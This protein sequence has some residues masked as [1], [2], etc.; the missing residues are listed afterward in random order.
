M[1]FL[2]RE[3]VD[4][5]AS[6]AGT[7][8]AEDA[9]GKRWTN[10]A[11]PLSHEFMRVAS[12]KESLVVLAADVPSIDETLKLIE[13]VGDSVCALKTHVDMVEGFNFEE[14]SMVVESA[15]AKGMLIFEDRKFADIGKVA[16]TQMSGLYD[17]RSWADLVT[18]H[19]LSGPDI[20]DGIAAGWEAVERIGGVL[21]LAQMSS[22]N[23][24]LDDTYTDETIRM[25]S[26]SPHVLGYIG[27]G[28][29]RS[30]LK[31]LRSK[32]GEGKMIWTPGVSLNAAE[33]SFGQRYGN[34]ADAVMAG[35]D[36]VI[37][38]SGIYDT[39][40]PAASAKEYAS[41]SWGALLER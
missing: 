22:S 40:D 24:L 35:S 34:P 39:Q 11:H 20:I 30:D 4:I 33:G 27:N 41:A 26:A 21:L 25:G 3:R 32:V 31:S 7:M 19:S 18:S 10:C 2:R 17:I 23:N 6:I 1:I 16:K 12:E 36:A 8:I 37:V 13:T 15:R 14:W 38:G 5:W 29:S 9:W 28:S